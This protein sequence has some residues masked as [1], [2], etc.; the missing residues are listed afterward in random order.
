[1]TATNEKGSVTA[2][3]LAILAGKYLTFIL[4]S[5]SYAMPV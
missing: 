1:M 3:S 2:K 4:G 5:E